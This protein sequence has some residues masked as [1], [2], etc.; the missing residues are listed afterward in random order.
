MKTMNIVTC[1]SN[2]ITKHM[3]IIFIKPTRDV[4]LLKA[5]EKVI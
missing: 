4:Y 3:D 1:I 5:Q 2:V